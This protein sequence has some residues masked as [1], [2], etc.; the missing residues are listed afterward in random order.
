MVASR[1][2]NE[3]IALICALYAYGSAKQIVKFLDSLDFSLLDEPEDTILKNTKQYYRFQTAQDTVQFFITLGRLKK[4][5]PLEE[6][7]LSGY[8]KESSVLHG[9]YEMIR[10]LKRVNDFRSF[11]YD[12]LLGEIPQKPSLSGVSPFKRY[13]MFLRWMVRHDCLD[14]GLWSR[15][16]K[17]DL[18]I[19]L[20]VHTSTVSRKLGL[21]N[22]KNNDMLAVIELTNKLKEFDPFD[23]I[24]YDFAIYRLGQNRS[25][26]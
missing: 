8:K 12:N 1:H 6:I 18:L 20:D 21:L 22:R 23:P 25:I 4:E 11:G 2:N 9:I 10:A 17:K 7:F 5:F 14:M 16:D 26:L 13:N 15:V 19:P 3:W 24:K